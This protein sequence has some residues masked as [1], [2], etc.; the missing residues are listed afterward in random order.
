MG[1]LLRTGHAQARRRTMT[2]FTTY[3]RKHD[4]STII[5]EA[6]ADEFA[7]TAVN[8]DKQDASK[9]ILFC[10]RPG[11]VWVEVRQPEGVSAC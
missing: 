11:G 2:L 4:P 1:E 3:Q 6:F 5:R 10:L 8:L 9:A 7:L